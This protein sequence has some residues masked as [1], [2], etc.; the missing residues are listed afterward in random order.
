MS[1][2]RLDCLARKLSL[3]LF[4][5]SSAWGAG[6]A[7][8]GGVN[9]MEVDAAEYAMVS[10]A[11]PAKRGNESIAS[12]EGD[13]PEDKRQKRK[14]SDQDNLVQAITKTPKGSA[15]STI[16]ENSDT[17]AIIL[18]FL[19]GNDKLTK[20]CMVSKLWC[21]TAYKPAAWHSIR[22]CGYSYREKPVS[23]DC[24]NEFYFKFLKEKKI[25][26]R[27]RHLSLSG[28]GD[29]D[30][31]TVAGELKNN[32]FV[33]FHV[34]R[35][36][37][38]FYIE[39]LQLL[40]GNKCLEN[41]DISGE[42][43]GDEVAIEF[44]CALKLTKYLRY[45]DISCTH[46][47]DEGAIALADPLKDNPLISFDCSYNFISSKGT[48]ALAGSLKGMKFL[49]EL[50]LGNNEIGDEGAIELAGSLKDSNSLKY[51]YIQDNGI[52]YRGARALSDL[53]KVNTSLTLLYLS[54]NQI[55]YEGV[56]ALADGL[57]SNRSLFTLNI[58]GNAIGDE[59]LI[60]FAAGL[61]A[62]N[63]LTNFNLSSNEIGDAGLIA[64]ARVLSK[65]KYRTYFDLS[66]NPI[67]DAGAIAL[68]ETL[69][70]NADRIIFHLSRNA[71]GKKGAK[72]LEDSLV[73][74]I[75]LNLG[76]TVNINYNPFELTF[77]SRR[78]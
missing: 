21:D 22:F 48:I 4:L 51:L 13:E 5:C 9:A 73:P 34:D 8:A 11:R 42:E 24:F 61:A 56:I 46:I 18:G 27:L 59:G 71:I 78:F 3:S 55:G 72:S 75:Y 30:V 16:L 36:D 33:T 31:L 62:N 35:S 15:Q 69:L 64:L 29:P 25:F 40:E 47:G 28:L 10:S 44:A 63:S 74:Y 57:A 37:Y 7:M 65:K 70:T 39:L 6:A 60:A 14:T 23:L 2:L 32:K 52:A 26:S 12:D 53:L 17:L 67:G 38:E 58:S 66:D 19:N 43:I 49:V 45:F 41:I 1:F 76:L 68:S 54:G 50:N 20:A 77:G